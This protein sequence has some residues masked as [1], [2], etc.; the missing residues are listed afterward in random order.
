[1]VKSEDLGLEVVTNS[2][3]DLAK[4]AGVPEGY[5]V[6]CGVI[7]RYGTAEDL[8]GGIRLDF[9]QEGSRNEGQV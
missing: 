2:N 4:Q 3:K 7:V 8:F 1:M 9:D 6:Q 5:A